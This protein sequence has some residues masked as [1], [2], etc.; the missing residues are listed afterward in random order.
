MRSILPQQQKSLELRW[1]ALRRSVHRA[2]KRLRDKMQTNS[3]R[4]TLGLGTHKYE[5]NR[6]GHD[7][8]YGKDA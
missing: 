2:E 3:K 7:E 5:S 8:V 6:Q 1:L 4:N